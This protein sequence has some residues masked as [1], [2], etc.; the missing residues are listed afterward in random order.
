MVQRYFRGWRAA[1]AIR[2][3][4]FPETPLPRRAKSLYRACVKH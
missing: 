1:I 2:I 3:D 4:F